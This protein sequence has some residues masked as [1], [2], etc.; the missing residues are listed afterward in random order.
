MASNSPRLFRVIMP[1]S[2]IERAAAFY[3]ELFGV[4]GV[5]VSDGRHYFDVGGVILA[6][7]D[8]RAD[9][10]D[11]DARPNPD[12][13]YFAVPDL[14]ACY[15]RAERLGGLSEEIGDGGLPMGKI[16]Q[17]PWGELS[18]YLKDPFGNS[19]CFVDEESVFTGS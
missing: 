6:V 4:E 11:F 13:L 5:R 12:H 17:R 19:L 2:G 9:G 1:V 10:D 7:F 3:T 14:E 16:A 8:P 15:G 18:F